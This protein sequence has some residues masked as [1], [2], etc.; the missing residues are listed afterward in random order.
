MYNNKDKVKLI[1]NPYLNK[2]KKKY[3]KKQKII[4]SIGRLC[5]QKNF[6]T[7]I[8]AFEIFSLKNKDYKLI[9]LGHG[10]DKQKLMNLSKN[11]G[12]E[13]KK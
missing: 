11:L 13:K 6:Q 4:L 8:K 7:L 9:I 5:K 10:P 1:F 12:I 2:S 3:Y